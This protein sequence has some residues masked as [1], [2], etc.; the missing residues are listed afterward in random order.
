MPARPRRL[1]RF[2]LR[3]RC[4]CATTGNPAPVAR[5]ESRRS[6]R[7]SIGHSSSSGIDR[8]LACEG[9]AI[10]PF[11]NPASS[12]PFPRRPRSARRAACAGLPIEPL[13]RGGSGDLDQFRLVEGRTASGHGRWKSRRRRRRRRQLA[14][15][16]L[17][18]RAPRPGSA[19]RQTTH[20]GCAECSSEAA[21]ASPAMRP[22]ATNTKTRSRSVPGAGLRPAVGLNFHINSPRSCS[23]RPCTDDAE[24][25]LRQDHRLR[26]P[27]ATRRVDLDAGF[28]GPGCMT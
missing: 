1:R 10:W 15:M 4:R 24:R 7:T 28:I 16:L 20:P 26:S 19:P 17:T 5:P 3:G 14:W 13:W 18:D 2:T 11:A 6:Q 23:S 12:Q 9:D 8:D 22:S 27:S 21:G 25:D